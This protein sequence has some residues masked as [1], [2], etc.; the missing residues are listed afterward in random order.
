MR[1]RR[2]RTLFAGILA[3]C[4]LPLN[5]TVLLGCKSYDDMKKELESTGV[6]LIDTVVPPKA[7]TGT[8]V[9]LRGFNFGETNGRVGFQ[10]ANGNVAV[11]EIISWNSDLV[12]TK[13]PTLVGTPEASAIHLVT[14]DG[15]VLAFPHN[16]TIE[17]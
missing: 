15:K 9:T 5:A 4:L 3:L 8:V 2:V 10:D 7:K 12:V 6:P 17:K 16:Y 13:V 14:A 1:T 11:A